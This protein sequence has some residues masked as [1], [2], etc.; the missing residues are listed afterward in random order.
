MI[1]AL[2]VV[3]VGVLLAVVV[4]VVLVRRHVP[5]E[6]MRTWL[7]ESLRS[8]RERQDPAAQA[9]LLERAAAGAQ[10][11][12]SVSDILDLAEEGPAYHTPVDLREVMERARPGR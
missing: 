9:D 12:L 4:V 10:R 6:G 2:L 1:D 8:V 5:A 7:G 11:P 3:A